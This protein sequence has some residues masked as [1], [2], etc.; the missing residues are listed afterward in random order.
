MFAAGCSHLASPRL[1][2][3]SCQASVLRFGKPLWGQGLVCLAAPVCR[4]ASGVGEA[5]G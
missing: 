3:L 4:E 1:A 5:E 2:L